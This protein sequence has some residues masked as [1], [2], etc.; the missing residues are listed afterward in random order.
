METIIDETIILGRKR[1]RRSE[2]KKRFLIQATLEHVIIWGNFLYSLTHVTY[3]ITLEEIQSN[4]S[5]MHSW[6]I[7]IKKVFN[8]AYLFKPFKE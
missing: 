4:W 1:M 2:G 7:T 6:K 3:I 8:V 5:I